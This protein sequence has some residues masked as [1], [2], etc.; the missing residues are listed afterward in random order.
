MLGVVAVAEPLSLPNCPLH[1]GGVR[2]G[3]PGGDTCF[4]SCLSLLILTHLHRL[5]GVVSDKYSLWMAGFCVSLTTR[6]YTQ[7]SQLFPPITSDASSF[8]LHW[9]VWTDYKH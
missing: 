9:L 1:V 2:G 7:S 6:P 5:D 4:F 8:H 3:E